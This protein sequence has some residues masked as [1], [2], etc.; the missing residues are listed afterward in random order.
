MQSPNILVIPAYVLVIDDD[1]DRLKALRDRLQ[2][3]FREHDQVLALD[4]GEWLDTNRELMQRVPV[5]TVLVGRWSGWEQ[6][7]IRQSLV[8]SYPDIPFYFI[9]GDGEPGRDGAPAMDFAAMNPINSRIRRILRDIDAPG[10]DNDGAPAGSPPD[11]DRPVWL[12]RGLSGTSAAIQSVR[13]D[14]TLVAASDSTVLITGAA[15][16]GKEIAARNIHFQSPRRLKPFVPVDCGAGSSDQLERDLFGHDDNGADPGGRGRFELADGGTLFLGDIGAMSLAMQF[17]LLRV[18]RER[19]FERVE[20]GMPRVVNVRI[21]AATHHD[22]AQLVVEGRFREDLLNCLSGFPVQMPSLKDR[23]EDLPVLVAE[24]QRKLR[25]HG[26]DGTTFSDAALDV[27]RRYSWPGNLRE[28][29]ET[30]ERLCVGRTGSQVDAGDLPPEI[31]SE[32]GSGRPPEPAHPDL[33]PA[34]AHSHPDGLDLERYLADM[35]RSL[36]RQALEESDGVTAKVAERL[37][38]G[39]EALAQK[40]RKHGF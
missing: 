12:F 30:V 35:E 17:K 7:G 2:G 20:G 28:L 15:G 32:A 21:V 31:L 25:T 26:A 11:N 34:A 16:T 23:I 38:L 8:D 40:M 22:L 19:T 37:N 13:N 10:A 14:I 9:D 18:L 1:S 29:S 6:A 27:L 39:H 5:Q 33:Q 3:V 24:V 36:I 4:S